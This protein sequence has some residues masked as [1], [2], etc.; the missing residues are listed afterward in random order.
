[1]PSVRPVRP[2]TM[3]S[4]PRPRI[5]GPITDSVTLTT[6]AASTAMAPLRSG[7][8]V[9]RSRRVEPT[10]SSDFSAGMPAAP[11]RPPAK[12][13]DGGSGL[14]TGVSSCPSLIGPPPP[15]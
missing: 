11:K 13:R 1:M 8:M 7:R 9:A 15:R 2:S 5:R 4:V 14:W 10:K 12:A 6:A 3:M